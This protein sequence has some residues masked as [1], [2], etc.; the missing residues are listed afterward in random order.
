MT[1]YTRS[2]LV[3]RLVESMGLMSVQ[4]RSRPPAEWSDLELT[5]PQARTLFLL[6]QGPKRMTQISEFL[7]RGMPAATSMIDRL[8]KK[9]LVERVE[10]ASDRR[11]VACR[12]TAQGQG[13]VERFW[14]M[15]RKRREAIA[16]ALT[17]EELE[18]VVP[19]IEV[20]SDAIRRVGP[21]ADAERVGEAPGKI[22]SPRSTPLAGP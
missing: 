2:E 20:L 10:E 15:G 6:S 14:R 4:M 21:L 18:V 17:F 13:V 3:E 12:L 7:G 8:V 1:E 5:M 11:V 9:V 16:A 19:A 22:K